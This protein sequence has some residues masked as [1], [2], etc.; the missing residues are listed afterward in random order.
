MQGLGHP[1]GDDPDSCLFR[2]IA[3]PTRIVVADVNRKIGTNGQFDGV[4]SRGFG[5]RE[6]LRPRHLFGKDDGADSLDEAAFGLRL[7][8]QNGRSQ[9]PGQNF[10]AGHN[11]TPR[12]LQLTTFSCTIA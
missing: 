7:Q 4:K 11:S 1:Q 12:S 10:A 2:G 3:Q 8:G 5:L 6:A 9:R